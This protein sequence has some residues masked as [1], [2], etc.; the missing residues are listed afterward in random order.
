M[1]SISQIQPHDTIRRIH[2]IQI[3]TITW[4]SIEA[5]VSLLAAWIARSPALL[6]FGGDSAIELLSAVVVLWRFKALDGREGA[7]KRAARI[8]GALLFILAAY[9]A[10]IS[11]TTLLGHA[12]PK[13][14]HLGIA[15]LIAALTVMPWLAAQKQRLSAATGSAALRAD[16]AQSSLC[17]YLSVVALVGLLINA[18]WHVSWADPSCSLSPDAAHLV[19]RQPDDTW[20]SLQ[21]LLER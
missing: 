7:E 4:M 15:I 18:L 11:V 14:S 17:A 1:V 6:G 9:V 20:K 19:G 8:T 12:E 13:P 2:R 3:I 16:A 21:L 5:V 10:G